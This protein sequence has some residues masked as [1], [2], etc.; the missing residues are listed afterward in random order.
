[1][2]ST[3]FR[4][5]DGLRQML[6]PLPSPALDRPSKWPRSIVNVLVFFPII[7]FLTGC[8][9]TKTNCSPAGGPN[10]SPC[11]TNAEPYPRAVVAAAELG[12][13]VIGKLASVIEWRKGHLRNQKDAKAYLLSKLRPL[14]LIVVSSKGKATHT[15]LPGTFIHVA[16][17]LGDAGDLRRLGVWNDTAVQ[18]HADKIKAGP[19]FIEADSKNVHLSTPDYVLNT[20]HVVI[21]RPTVRTRKQKQIALKHF[22]AEIGTGFDYHFNI[23]DDG[24]M[25]CAE[26][27][28]HVLNHQGIPTQEVYGRNTIVPD[29]IL[30]SVI[31]GK[32][33]LRFVAYIRGEN[34]S[35]SLG[36]KR[37]LRRDLN[38]ANGANKRSCS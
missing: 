15:L 17:Y 27:A 3:V 1:M 5:A 18:A 13:P 21:L 19:Q 26:L 10:S 33:R 38:T 29:Q 4:L 23:D 14:D 30:A 24:R 34:G 11:T 28:N 9:T 2:V 35:W 6:S 7:L 8:G 32:S 31:E 37:D 36:S 25:F 20:D 16:V 22:F 12:A